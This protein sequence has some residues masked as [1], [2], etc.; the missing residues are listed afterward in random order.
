MSAVHFTASLVQVHDNCRGRVGNQETD[1]ERNA[2]READSHHDAEN[3]NG[4]NHQ[5][6]HTAYQHNLLH[7]EQILQRYFQADGKHQQDNA[8]FREHR[9][10]RFGNQ[11]E[12]ERSDNNTG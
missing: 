9:H 1:E 5:L 8:E 7:R 6:K 11:A 3:R 4:G 12:T 10:F 2:E